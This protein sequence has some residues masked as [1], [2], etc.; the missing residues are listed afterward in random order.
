LQGFEALVLKVCGAKAAKE[1]DTK[2]RAQAAEIARRRKQGKDITIPALNPALAVI[3][4][5][6]SVAVLVVLGVFA[7]GV[8]ELRKPRARGEKIDRT[9]F[10]TDSEDF[11]ARVFIIAYQIGLDYNR[12]PHRPKDSMAEVAVKVARRGQEGAAGAHHRK[13]LK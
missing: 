13:R 10:G 4:N 8:A 11:V 2:L 5:E 12:P 9:P 7:A 1:I 6:A 3:C